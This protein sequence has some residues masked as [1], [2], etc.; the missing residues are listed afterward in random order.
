MCETFLSDKTAKI[1]DVGCGTGLVGEHL[2]RFGFKSLDGLEPAKQMISIA[3]T[4]NI[5]RH[6]YTE[7]VQ[8]DQETSIP[9][10]M[11]ILSDLQSI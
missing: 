5:Y 3:Q 4:K 11:F 9:K 6:I 2:F 7:S 8:D 1:L 10:G